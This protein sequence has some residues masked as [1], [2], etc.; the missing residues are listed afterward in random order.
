[1]PSPLRSGIDYRIKTIEVDD[2]HIKLQIWCEAHANDA[3]SAS[4][5]A[6][7]RR[8]VGGLERFHTLAPAFYRGTMGVVLVYDVTKSTS[9]DS[10]A[11][12]LR[13]LE[14]HASDSM[15]KILLGNNCHREDERQVPRER[16]EQVPL[17]Q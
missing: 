16:A 12:W 6:S 8:T 2:K 5:A 7:V 10:V 17:P 9:F 4:P 15:Q 14:E 3:S 11:R 13:C 1:M